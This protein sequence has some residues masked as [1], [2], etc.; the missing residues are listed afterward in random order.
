MRRPLLE[1]SIGLTGG[2]LVASVVPGSTTRTSLVI[3]AA[4]L[5]CLAPGPV[6]RL[7]IVLAAAAVGALSAATE[8]G[9]LPPDHIATLLGHS[10]VLV[11][12]EGRVAS[13]PAPGRGTRHAFDLDVT[14]IG[15]RPGRAARGTIRVLIPPGRSLDPG[16]LVRVLGTASPT[17][18]PKP[19]LTGRNHKA[20]ARLPG[21]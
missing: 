18:A 14:T 10:P 13:A 9:A 3:G 2:L 11:T 17:R 12:L 5:A 6:R 4:L 1:A 21:P 15:R 7:R 8:D 19:V 20:D 16:D